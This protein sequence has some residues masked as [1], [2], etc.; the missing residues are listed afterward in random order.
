MACLYTAL[1][2]RRHEK[3]EASDDASIA[4]AVAEAGLPESVAAAVDDESLD[5]AVR[6][7]AQPLLGA[8]KSCNGRIPSISAC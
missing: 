5:V 6:A 4:A 7:G 8:Q 1:G 2:T 3:G